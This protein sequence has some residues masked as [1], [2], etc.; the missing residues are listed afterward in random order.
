M[1][2]LDLV[3]VFNVFQLNDGSFLIKIDLDTTDDCDDDLIT[4]YKSKKDENE[5]EDD[6]LLISAKDVNE[7]AMILKKY[8]PMVKFKTVD[9]ISKNFDN[10]IEFTEEVNENDTPESLFKKIK[11]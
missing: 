2:D 4:L 3:S 8:L 10:G 7:V 1:D 6:D 11:V 9:D 5:D